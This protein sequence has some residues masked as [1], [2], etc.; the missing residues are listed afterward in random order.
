MEVGAVLFP[1]SSESFS[2]CCPL[3]ISLFP[4]SSLDH[5]LLLVLALTLQLSSSLLP[6][7]P[8]LPLSSFSPSGSPTAPYVYANYGRPSDFS[9]LASLN[10][11]V[12]GKI[13]F[14]RYGECFRGLK[15]MNA[16]DR[17]AVG[18]VVF[19]DPEDDGYGR[20]DTYPEGPWRSPESVQRGSVQFNSLCAGGENKRM[21]KRRGWGERVA[22]SESCQ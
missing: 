21:D 17:G 12:T 7:P 9:T 18:V 8:S 4:L 6:S 14:V 22:R 20:G 10:I 11:T 3:S 2:S 15:V 5:P 16:Q 19:S 13:V 1:V